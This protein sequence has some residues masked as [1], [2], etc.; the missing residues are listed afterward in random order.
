MAIFAIEQRTKE[1]GVRKVLGASVAGITTML[2]MDFLKLVL[3]AI[4]IASPVAWYFMHRWLQ[5]FA[6]RIEIHWGIFVWA[7]FLAVGIAMLT[8]SFQS[9]KAALVNPVKSLKRE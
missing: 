9:I 8:V 4:V 6:Y 2:S 1:I 7:G 5:D 3:V